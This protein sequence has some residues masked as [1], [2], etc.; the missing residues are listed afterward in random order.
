M[1]IFRIR[2]FLLFFLL[3]FSITLKAEVKPLTPP[4]DAPDVPTIDI[5]K[6][7]K[8]KIQ[9][10]WELTK[11]EPKGNKV[12]I[13]AKNSKGYVSN[14]VK[15]IKSALK[16]NAKDFGKLGKASVY[17]FVITKALEK[18]FD[19]VKDGFDWLFDE[20]NNSIQWAENGGSGKC[21]IKKNNR[22]FR[23]FRGDTPEEAC[24]NA[25]PVMITAYGKDNP[26]G[27]KY[28]RVDNIRKNEY[29]CIYYTTDE[30]FSRTRTEASIRCE[31]KTEAETEKKEGTVTL[32]KLAEM[33]QQLAQ[34][35]DK[36]AQDVLVDIAK[37][38]F[39]KKK[40][41]EE[42]EKKKKKEKDDDKDKRDDDDDDDGEGDDDDD[43]DCNSNRFYQKVCEWMKWTKKEPKPPSNNPKENYVDIKDGTKDLKKKFDRDLFDFRRQCPPPHVLTINVLGVS[44]TLTYNY[45]PLCDAFI[46]LR[47]F[48]IGLGIIVGIMIVAGRRK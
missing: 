43:D 33:I 19:L 7:P 8:P 6:P 37:E 20:E 2:S 1:D 45:Q 31:E 11:I 38:E 24:Q 42:L 34:Q 26:Y 29:L 4:K 21:V 13:F 16:K 9:Q 5:V 39:K 22:T 28:D 47:P 17:G 48:V 46:K 23:T 15:K 18:G 25:E 10:T 44:K 14:I 3:F 30:N 36:Q 35:G 40:Y 32:D 27:F 41:D 12:Q